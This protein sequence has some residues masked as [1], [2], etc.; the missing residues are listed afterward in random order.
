MSEDL[1]IGNY[2]GMPAAMHLEEFASQVWAAFG[3]APYLVG[4]ATRS[5]SWRDVDVRLMLSDEQYAALGLRIDGRPDAKWTAICMAFAALGRQMTG[6]PIDFQIQREV[7]ANETYKGA[8][9]PLAM[10]ELRYKHID[11][12]QT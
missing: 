9:I 8:R 4:S 5:K 3:D 7:T 12:L 11:E 2:V 1:P 10:I 6:L